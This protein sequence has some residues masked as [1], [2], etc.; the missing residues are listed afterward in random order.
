[1]RQVFCRAD[2]VSSPKRAIYSEWPESASREL[3]QACARGVSHGSGARRRAELRADV[4]H[5]A[6]HGVR[7]QEETRGD[8]GVAIAVGYEAQD[9]DLADGQLIPGSAGV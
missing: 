5:V 4:R 7:A 6:M 1:M 3:E 2:A 8:L 9:L